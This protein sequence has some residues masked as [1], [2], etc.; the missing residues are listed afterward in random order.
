MNLQEVE[1]RLDELFRLYRK[2]SIRPVTAIEQ[3]A[4][5]LLLR[6]LDQFGSQLP[7]GDLGFDHLQPELRWSGMTKCF[8]GNHLWDQ[9]GHS[10]LSFIQGLAEDD[11]LQAVGEAYR[12]ISI[13]QLIPLGSDR[14]DHVGNPIGDGHFEFSVEVV[15]PEAPTENGTKMQRANAHTS[16]QAALVCAVAFIDSLPLDCLEVREGLFGLLLRKFRGGKGE[17]FTPQHV[18]DIMVELAQPK[19]GEAVAD[20]FCG[21]GSL[22]VEARKYMHQQNSDREVEEGTFAG[23][24]VN[25]TMLRLAAVNLLLNGI[26]S[27]QLYYQDSFSGSFVE[28]RPE[29][30]TAA[31]DL[32]FANAP[33]G[34]KVKDIAPSLLE[35]VKTKRSDKLSLSLLLRML[36]KDGRACAVVPAGLLWGASRAHTGIR[37]LLVES[38]RLEAVVSFP[39]AALGSRPRVSFSILYFRKSGR[40]D[41]VWFFDFE[42]FLRR[43]DEIEQVG[44]EEVRACLESWRKRD[45]EKDV[46]RGA[47]AFFVSADEI[48][49]RSYELCPTRYRE[50]FQSEEDRESPSEVWDRIVSFKP[51]SDQPGWSISWDGRWSELLLNESL[52]SAA[53]QG[54]EFKSLADVCAEITEGSVRRPE[55]VREGVPLVTAKDLSRGRL[56]LRACR[57]ISEADHLRYG[58]RCSPKALDILYSRTG[59]K[60]GDMALVETTEPIALGWGVV[61]LEPDSQQVDSNYLYDILASNELQSQAA[62]LAGGRVRPLLS[63][64]DIER[65]KIPVIPS[66]DMQSSIVRELEKMRDLKKDFFR[67][68]QLGEELFNSWLHKVIGQ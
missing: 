35:E 17:Y 45:P 63:L 44:E 32:V 66:L 24:D 48:R 20:P 62:Q 43:K 12:S 37:K 16:G 55:Y 14:T 33:F 30:A 47:A 42:R 51:S 4:F 15:D 27:P 59:V 49:K 13:D 6:L 18:L 65:L 34:S 36:K 54:W 41:R 8:D 38:N 40:T 19:Q 68:S 56:D 3:L 5:I 57:R 67:L 22:L 23:F 60:V 61:L 29:S 58:K 7:P 28:D 26:E 10:G 21:A 53:H 52:E 2:A 31:F 50:A 1:K 11:R 64:A 25:T 39:H 9:L 46:D